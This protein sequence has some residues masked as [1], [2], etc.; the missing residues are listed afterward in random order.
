MERW[1]N[2]VKGLPVTKLQ[3]YIENN[4]TPWPNM[5]PAE[6][7]DC[8]WVAKQIFTVVAD[9]VIA[10]IENDAAVMPEENLSRELF[11]ALGMNK[12]EDPERCR[13]DLLVLHGTDSVTIYDYKFGQ[14]LEDPATDPQMISYAIGVNERFSFS[15]VNVVKLNG[16]HRKVIAGTLSASIL[17]NYKTVISEEIKKAE[18]ADAPRTAGKVQCK[19]CLA[20]NDCPAAKAF[21]AAISE[22]E[23][24]V[25]VAPEKIS[26]VKSV[27][28]FLSLTPLMRG[29]LLSALDESLAQF[30]KL[31]EDIEAWALEAGN[32]ADGIY[33]YEIGKGRGGRAW[34]NEIE[35]ASSMM[36]LAKENGKLEADLYEP[37]TLLSPAGMEKVFTGVEAKIHIASL[38]TPITP[39]QKL[40]RTK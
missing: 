2:W 9:A 15:N 26:A 1:V 27:A 38:V 30:K 3:Q 10:G 16:M 33:G 20:R 11:Q 36:L 40:V 6:D 37:K 29:A 8:F 19:Y 14:D 12:E 22:H 13:A 21:S 31:R 23:A 34:R 28:D 18:K 39:K 17:E 32:L 7:E 24:L 35:A 4:I 25:P 5:I